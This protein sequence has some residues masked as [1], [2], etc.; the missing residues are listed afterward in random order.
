MF[1]IS[2]IDDTNA[3]HH[4]GSYEP[5]GKHRCSCYFR[6]SKQIFFVNLKY[7]MSA[8]YLRQHEN[9]IGTWWLGRTVK[10]AHA[11]L[12]RGTAGRVKLSALL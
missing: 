10:A 6:V 11:P 1:T 5:R 3:S 8:L 12:A 9:K 7:T 4:P 2:W